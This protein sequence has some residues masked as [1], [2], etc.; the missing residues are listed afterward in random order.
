MTSRRADGDGLNGTVRTLLY[1][2]G[3]IVGSLTGPLLP[4]LSTLILSVLCLQAQIFLYIWVEERDGIRTTV[5]V[6]GVFAMLPLLHFL[7]FRRERVQ[8]Q[9]KLSFSLFSDATHRESSRGAAILPAPIASLPAAHI[10][11]PASYVG[12]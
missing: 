5:S 10:A 12:Y 11:R 8:D 4:G 9:V 6:A 2:V 3:P 1:A 7:P